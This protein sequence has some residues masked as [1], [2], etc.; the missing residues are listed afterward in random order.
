MRLFLI[1]F[2]IMLSSNVYSDEAIKYSDVPENHWAKEAIDS[3]TEKGIMQGYS[4]SSF[5]G[6][7]YLTRYEFAV[8]LDRMVEFIINSQ[9]PLVLENKISSNKHWAK[10]SISNLTEKKIISKDFVNDKNGNSYITQEEVGNLLADAAVM[11]IES[12]VPSAFEHKD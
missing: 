11:I 10:Q 6:D 4:D 1:L 2:I 5:K 7:N 3:L 8:A 9:K 12:T